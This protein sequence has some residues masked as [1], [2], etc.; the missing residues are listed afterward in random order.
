G[1][2][3]PEGLHPTR[4]PSVRHRP[5]GESSWATR[6]YRTS[7]VVS[8][9]PAVVRRTLLPTPSLAALDLTNQVAP[10]RS[11]FLLEIAR[12]R[13]RSRAESAISWARR[14]DARVEAVHEG[15][16]AALAGRRH[17]AHG[18]VARLTGSG[19]RLESRGLGKRWLTFRPD[20]GPRWWSVQVR[21]AGR[22]QGG[23]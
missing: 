18:L 13:V 12:P 2:R 10:S 15:P 4:F 21:R 17:G 16:R 11:H 5:L 7:G 6:G 8:S 23:N 1:I 3:T 19:G 20:V 22:R 14:E 9:S